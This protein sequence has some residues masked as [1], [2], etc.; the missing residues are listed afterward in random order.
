[1]EDNI[2]Q[3]IGTGQT[4]NRDESDSMGTIEVPAEHY[5]GAQTQRSLIH[6]SIGNDKMPKEVYHAYGYVKKAAALVNQSD[7]R[8]PSEIANTIAAVAD[9]VINKK[10]DSEFPLYVWQTGSGTQSNMNVNEVISNRAIQ[11]LGGE[12]GSKK[13][14]HPN[15]HVNMGQS[16][17][18]SFPTAM[19]IAAILYID[20]K[21][22]PAIE[23]L[24]E[25][26]VA[27]SKLWK[28]VVKIGRTHLQDAVPLTVGQEWSGYATQLDDALERVKE[29]RIKLFEIAAGGTAVGTGLNAPA[30][31]AKK[32]ASQIAMLTGKPFITAPNKFAAQGS[33][34]AMVAAM[35]GLR[36]LAVALMKIANDMRWLASG[37]RCGIGELILP[38]NEP[39]SSIMPGKINPTQCEA[40]VMIC[41]QV[42]GED[43]A[44]AFAGSQGNFELNAM[45]PIVINNFLHAAGILADGAEKFR[46][47]S[48]EGT[49]LNLP[50]IEEFLNRSLMLVT[51]LSPEI[52]YDKASAIAHA[53][54]DKNL[55]LKEA[56][57]ASGY[58]DEDNF[59]RIADPK[60]MV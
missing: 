20:D 36:G 19:H 21:L 52:G 22:V 42:I 29:S 47:F 54:L 4:G 57:L 37:P 26:I 27:K 10:L 33:L 18:D 35:S 60:K 17:N 30:G 8:L 41:I 13:P 12:L 53:A 48:V 24:K 1:M 58:I 11:L 2:S 56:A 34:D 25:A 44:V 15:D 28:D 7:G 46:M 59:D 50:R 40:M 5:W 51:A 32:I 16:S 43:N 45:R 6:F 3:P 9:E 39:G 49:E 55:T 23:K 14:V 38:P 31:F